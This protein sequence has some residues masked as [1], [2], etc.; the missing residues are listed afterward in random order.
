MSETRASAAFAPAV[1]ITRAR[2]LLLCFGHAATLG[3]GD[4]DLGALV[5]EGVAPLLDEVKVSGGDR[6]VVRI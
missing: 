2:S 5:A 1:A 4:D 6:G 3:G